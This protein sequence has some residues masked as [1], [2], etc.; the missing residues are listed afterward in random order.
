MILVLH[1]GN[2]DIAIG[3][4]DGGELRFSAEIS[5]EPRRSADEY[6]V[7]LA[8]IFALRQFRAEQITDVILSSVVPSLTDTVCAAV[9]AFVPQ[10]P[11]LVGAGIRTGLK[12]RVDA[13]AQL[14]AD[15]VALACGARSYF[16]NGVCVIAQLDTATTLTV[17]SS[18]D[19]V[20][21]VVIMP[22]VASSAAALERDTAQ[23]TEISLTPPRRVIGKNTADAVRAGLLIGCAEQLDGLLER[24]AAELA[25]SPDTMTLLAVG[26][27]AQRITPLCSH[28]FRCVP[29]LLLEGLLDIYRRNT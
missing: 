15:L 9:A 5:T 1:I 22:G 27:Y 28:S 8:Q 12:L 21:G 13:P 20:A 10:K 2:T 4:Y 11:I 3:A 24:I 14:G 17:L 7:L 25:V 19:E 29:H 16:H 18:P 23:L 6:A 26:K